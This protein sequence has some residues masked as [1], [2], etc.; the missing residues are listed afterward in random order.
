MGETYGGL[1]QGIWGHEKGSW[2]STEFTQLTLSPCWTIRNFFEF[3]DYDFR[4][5]SDDKALFFV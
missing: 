4:V 5:L 2:T 1:F 3:L